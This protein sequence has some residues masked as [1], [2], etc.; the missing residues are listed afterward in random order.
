M[1][2]NVL[3]MA[4]FV[5]SFHVERGERHDAVISRA[6]PLSHF[7]VSGVHLGGITIQLVSRRRV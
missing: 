1:K 6:G 3:T 7:G 4:R 2:D 5:L